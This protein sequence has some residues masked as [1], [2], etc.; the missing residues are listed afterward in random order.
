MRQWHRGMSASSIRSSRNSV[1][2]MTVV[3]HS[4]LGHTISAS[5]TAPSLNSQVIHFR[6]CR[7]LQIDCDLG[8]NS[9]HQR[10]TA[11]KKTGI[12][13]R[14]GNTH[15]CTIPHPHFHPPSHPYPL[16]SASPVK[17]SMLTADSMDIA[18]VHRKS[19]AVR[20]LSS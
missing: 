3:A 13:R 11:A 5:Q 4:S 2:P 19:P 20:E 9:R 12:H 8:T 14:L 15:P 16:A 10:N 7:I 1:R 17:P 6:P 18:V